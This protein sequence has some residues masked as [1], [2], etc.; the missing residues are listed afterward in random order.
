MA[1]ARSWDSC[2]SWPRPRSSGRW[3][4]ATG[5]RSSTSPTSASSWPTS[6]SSRAASYS[7]P[8]PAAARSPPRWHALSRRAAASTHS[9]STS[10]EPPPRGKILRGMA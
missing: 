5:R 3:C 7:S 10:R 9:T 4:S 1:A 2:T 6:S 8:V